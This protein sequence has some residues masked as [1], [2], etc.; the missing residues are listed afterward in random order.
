MG[1]GSVL[2]VAK[3]KE[4]VGHGVSSVLVSC[5]KEARAAGVGARVQRWMPGLQGGRLRAWH[6]SSMGLGARCCGRPAAASARPAPA[7]VAA[8]TLPELLP[9]SAA[10]PFAAGQI[11]PN[12]TAG[13]LRRLLGSSQP[14]G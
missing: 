2:K 9:Q 5:F 1:D 10:A 6:G 11:Q 7:S 12:H 14:A 8:G 4:R 3:E 13:V